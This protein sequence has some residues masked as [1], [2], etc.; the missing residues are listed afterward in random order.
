MTKKIVSPVTVPAGFKTIAN[1]FVKAVSGHTDA[2]AAFEATKQT[3]TGLAL[4]CFA[5][6]GTD[7]TK[8]VWALFKAS[9]AVP[10]D[11]VTQDSDGNKHAVYKALLNAKQLY[12]VGENGANN[13][14]KVKAK[15]GASTP[16]AADKTAKGD[17]TDMVTKGASAA[18]AV[19]PDA[20]DFRKPRAWGALAKS[21]GLQLGER[22]K[23]LAIEAIASAWGLEFSWGE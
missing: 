16:N 10:H 19:A 20:P 3:A 5:V 8:L 11:A 17:K 21:V 12:D 15:P 2:L 7:Q 23:Q 14:R 1:K 13:G 6:A 18:P 9:K 22:D 4:E